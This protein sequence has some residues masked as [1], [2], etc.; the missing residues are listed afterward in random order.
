MLKSA[1][2]MLALML[3]DDGVIGEFD[4][5]VIGEFV[6]GEVR[7]LHALS[8]LSGGGGCKTDRISPFTFAAWCSSIP[9]R[10]SW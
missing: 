7:A 1:A 2:A 10:R 6:R 4:D 5:G 9:V 3:L 8:A